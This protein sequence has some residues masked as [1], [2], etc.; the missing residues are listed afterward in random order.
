ML[1]VP[2]YSLLT[3]LNIVIAEVVHSVEAPVE[4]LSSSFEC[5]EG[6]VQGV[7]SAEDNQVPHLTTV[8]SCSVREI[9][10]MIGNGK[11]F[12][13]MK[14]NLNGTYNGL[15]TISHSTTSLV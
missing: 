10:L 6:D 15:D 8:G 11:I 3:K 1:G 12:C 5:M 14:L 9:S 4:D 2:R 7:P 13:T